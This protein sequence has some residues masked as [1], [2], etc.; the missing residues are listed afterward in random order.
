MILLKDVLAQLDT[1]RE[2]IVKYQEQKAVENMRAELAANADNPNSGIEL[3]EK[4]K[5]DFVDS[6]TK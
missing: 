3:I 5:K 2:L 6:F 1:T 4:A